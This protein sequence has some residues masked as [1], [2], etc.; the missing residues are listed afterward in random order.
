MFMRIFK[1]SAVTFDPKE[2]KGC[3]D[4]GL[5]WKQRNVGHKW[6]NKQVKNRQSVD[7]NSFQTFVSKNPTR[8]QDLLMMNEPPEVPSNR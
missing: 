5:N 6:L 2:L 8:E 1:L 4:K 7:Q 3:A